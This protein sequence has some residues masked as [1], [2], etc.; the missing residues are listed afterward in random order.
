VK[1]VKCT[2]KPH[3]LFMSAVCG[4]NGFLSYIYIARYIR[5]RKDTCRSL[6]KFVVRCVRYKGKFIQ[7]DNCSYILTVSD[8]MKIRLE[9]PENFHAYGST[10][11]RTY[12]R[13]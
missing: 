12:E 8:F 4:R 10:V 2:Q 5:M 9:L 6:R 13:T 7:L 3:F 1:V 11:E